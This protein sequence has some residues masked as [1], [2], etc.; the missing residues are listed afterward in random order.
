MAGLHNSPRIVAQR[1]AFTIFGHTNEPME[2]IFEDRG[3]PGM[4]A[5]KVVLP[6]SDLPNLRDALFGIGYADSMIY[7]D[8]TGLAKEI[9][10]HFGFGV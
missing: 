2:K 9:K 4:G 7:P 8:L 3:F 5:I 10:R 1:G 6:A